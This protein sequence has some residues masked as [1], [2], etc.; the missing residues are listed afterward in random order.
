VSRPAD[1]PL[2][3]KEQKKI[4]TAISYTADVITSERLQAIPDRAIEYVSEQTW[5]KVTRGW[6]RRRCTGLAE[7]ARQILNGK[8]WLHKTMAD[9]FGKLLRRWG[10]GDIER[11]FAEELVRRLP[12]PYL[13]QKLTATARALQIT[14]IFICV[15]G[16]ND[17]RNCACFVDLVLNEGKEKLKDLMIAATNDWAHLHHLP[18]LA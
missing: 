4:E 17:L 2:N 13:D 15:M 3:K 18:E 1:R 9:L 6:K 12:F 11:R 8:S 10:V 5:K 14:G 16:D 7:L